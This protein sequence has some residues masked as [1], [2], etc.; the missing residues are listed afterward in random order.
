[1]ASAGLDCAADV[2]IG[3]R[4]EGLARDRLGLTDAVDRV[5]ERAVVGVAERQRAAAD[6]GAGRAAGAAYR[7]KR[8]G[9]ERRPRRL[10]QRSG[11]RIWRRL[12]RA[13]HQPPGLARQV[14]GKPRGEN[15]VT[16]L[17]EVDAP[18]GLRPCGRIPPQA[19]IGSRVWRR[20]SRRPT[21]EESP[22]TK[23]P[24]H[25]PPDSPAAVPVCCGLEVKRKLARLAGGN[26]D[27]YAAGFLRAGEVVDGRTIQDDG[28]GRQRRR[29]KVLERHDERRRLRS[30]KL[31][32]EIGTR[33]NEIE[34]RGSRLLIDAA[35]V[36][37]EQLI[38]RAARVVQPQPAGRLARGEGRKQNADRA[39]AARGQG[40]AGRACRRRVECRARRGIDAARR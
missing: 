30:Y 36:E 28:A 31:L 34:R 21:P 11:E 15:R 33:R 29:P 16:L 4:S 10:K 7:W 37:R 9:V 18:A 25:R 17:R 2:Q 38:R 32:A 13:H 35:T 12:V 24:A 23:A 22:A 20:S 5:G 40:Q 19:F 6:R 3:K 27:A 26:R 39:F 8:N 14:V 1:M